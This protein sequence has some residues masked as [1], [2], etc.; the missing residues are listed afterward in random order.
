[1]QIGA[2]R[3]LC[4]FCW[5]LTI[6]V[7][8]SFF[9]PWDTGVCLLVATVIAVA[10]FVVGLISIFCKRGRLQLLYA[11]FLLLGLLA[12]VVAS[13][14]Y[15]YRTVLPAQRY[16]ESTQ[17]EAV[18]LRGLV[19]SREVESSYINAYGVRVQLPNGKTCA[20][21]LSVMGEEGLDVGDEIRL[22]ATLTL[23]RDADEQA[24]LIRHLQAK[25]YMLYA[26]A[27]FLPSDA[28][29]STG[30]FVLREA[31][32][33][34]QGELSYRLSRAIGGEQGR[35][36]AAL[37]LGTRERLSDATVLDF[38]R[39]GASHLLALS[40][41]HL[42]MIVLMLDALLRLV[43]CPYRLRVL[44][45]CVVAVLFLLL[46]GCSISTLR[47][48]VMLLFL[49]VSRLRGA[50]HDSLTPLSLFLALCLALRPS[51][52]LDVGLWLS[53]LAA[54]CV[55]EIIPALVEKTGGQA[56]GILPRMW[57]YIKVS[58]ISSMIVLLVLLVP[59]ALFFGETAW[60]SPVAN[61]V[62]IPLATIALTLGLLVLPLLYLSGVGWIFEVLSGAL[63]DALYAI[64]G[65]MIKIAAQL[66]DVKG[67]LISLRYDF[68]PYLLSVLLVVLLAFLLFKWKRPR[69]V[70][71]LLAAWC[72]AFGAALTI[73]HMQGIGHWQA[74]YT[75]H[76][77]SELLALNQGSTTVL[78]DVSDGSYTTY[79]TWLH[80]GMPDGTTEVEAIVLTHYH[81]RHITS[82]YKLLGDVR[83]RSIYL[84]LTMPSA[85]QDKARQDEGI[86]RS[87][88]E[89]ARERR[90]NV[91]LYLPEEGATITSHLTLERLDY[92]ILKRSTHPTFAAS[93]VYRNDDM[94]AES[95]LYL[96][97]ASVWES[98]QSEQVFADATAC[99]ALLLSGHGPKIKSSYSMLDW[100]RAP[101]FVVFGSGDAM[102]A[103]DSNAVTTEA[104]A[105]AVIVFADR[106]KTTKF[107][108]P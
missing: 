68:V 73:T 45:L 43:R 42:S 84:P 82:V 108:L 2:A 53:V 38:R 32:A 102:V 34:V 100:T 52:I 15:Q 96:L 98:E 1:M 90:V 103:L 47:A 44:L 80:G 23:V 16:A 66:S 21:Y 65:A 70:V 13:L 56:K 39:T 17:G 25:G 69:R 22:P 60:L 37:L 57:R 87:I 33:G 4:C 19:I 12:G 93:W 29:V 101:Q 74:S 20:T 63:C 24:W 86:L 78:C 35:L 18:E 30:H 64:T 91:C 106:G 28:V 107:D 6:G 50:P 54:L 104:F 72:I 41:L 77:K 3:P 55:V 105:D 7:A 51:W 48:T 71:A 94:D 95:R 46:T 59:M 36:T 10:V 8:I 75:V 62:L 11:A 40:G 79:R 97:G 89:L 49:S 99:D 31:L 61:L 14:L 26:E 83:V 67:A 76:G 9:A 92:D 85:T 58:L 81:Q 5:L 27:E 88:M